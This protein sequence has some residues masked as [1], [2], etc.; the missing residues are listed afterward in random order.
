MANTNDGNLDIRA[1]RGHVILVHLP[2]SYQKWVTWKTGK[3]GDC[4]WGHYFDSEEE[5]WDDF[6]ERAKGQ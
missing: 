4:F 3:D 5:A 2:H 6:H 1:R